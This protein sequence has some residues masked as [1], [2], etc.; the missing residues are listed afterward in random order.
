MNSNSSMATVS[1]LLV[2][3]TWILTRGTPR[4]SLV[5]CS[6]TSKFRYSRLN[7]V[8]ISL[9]SLI[10]SRHRDKGQSSTS[11]TPRPI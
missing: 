2:F 10:C 5:F 3:W 11:Y 7:S 1:A 6:A 8:Q 4:R 9:H